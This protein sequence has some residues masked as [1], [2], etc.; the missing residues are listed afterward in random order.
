MTI[1][2]LDM[3]IVA[4]RCS[5]SAEND[6]V[7]VAL[8]R[9]DDLVRRILH[10]TNVTDYIGYL[11]GPNN[12][13]YE[14]YPLYKANRKDKPKPVHLEAC[15]EHLIVKWGSKV[16]DG[17]EADDALGIDHQAEPD[18]VLASIDKDL[19]QLPGKHYNF[20][21]QEFVTISPLQGM[22]NFY[23][24]LLEGDATDNIPAFD[25]KFRNTR[26]KFV[27]KF[28]DGLENMTDPFEM[29]GYV[30]DIW[31]VY[32]G[33]WDVNYDQFYINAQ[34]LYIQKKENDK[35]EEPKDWENVP[36]MM[37]SGAQDDFGPSSEPL[38]E[39]LQDDGDLNT[40]A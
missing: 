40:D 25:G 35:W 11:T 31:K 4:Y 10:E 6:P 19:L 17:I 32:G 21:K 16:T 18:S 33:G 12:F 9:I 3:D 38:L 28:I 26:P 1:A 20:V 5:A 23:T 15:K 8:F 36:T 27:Q 34:C 39:V 14:L 7:E 2:L 13:R 37:D 30:Q 22:R 24:Q 29:C